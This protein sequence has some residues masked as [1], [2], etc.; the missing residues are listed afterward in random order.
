MF[1]SIMV[2][3]KIYGLLYYGEN[4][5]YFQFIKLYEMDYYVIPTE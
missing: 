3:V 2:S 4:K 1:Y 5:C